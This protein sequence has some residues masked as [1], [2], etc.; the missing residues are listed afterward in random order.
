MSHLNLGRSALSVFVAVLLAACDGSQ[1]PIGGPGAM[2][3][4]TGIRAANSARAARTIEHRAAPASSF[5]VLFNFNGTDGEAPEDLINVKGTLF[6]TTARGGPYF[7]KC[8]EGFYGC[9]TVFSI[10]TSGEETV[11]YRFK[12]A[13]RSDG[14]YPEALIHVKGT[15]YGTTL[16]GGGHACGT[17]CGTVFSLT[18]GGAEKVLHIFSGGSDGA[19]PE[20]SLINVNGTLYGTTEAGG[21]SSGCYGGCGTVYSVTTKGKEKVLYSFAGWPDGSQPLAGLIDVNGTLY[22]T[23]SDGGSYTRCGYIPPGCGT[24]YSIT[25][26]GREKVVYSFCAQS[27]P[28]CTDGS[29]PEASLI[30]VKGTP[31]GTTYGG[32]ANDFG[33]VFSVT[34]TGTHKIVYSFCSISPD[35]CTDGANPTTSV[36]SV[37]GTLY[38]TTLGGG[39]EYRLSP[40]GLVYSVSTTGTERVLHNFNGSDGAVPSSNLITVKGTLYGTTFHG[41]RTQY[42]CITKRG[43]LIGCGTVFAFTP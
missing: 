13:G 11:L 35:A 28:F 40:A 31:Y 22:G 18:T 2:Q 38:G 34:T 15:L 5:N 9:G 14:A 27:V 32:G 12:G 36:I 6:G 26:T 37:K 29:S 24:V 30:D 41:G 17:G 23:T 7:D 8:S 42:P 33:T 19:Y 1:P 25:T 20:G 4:D 43:Y 10:T 16:Q 3:Q 21:G 39:Y